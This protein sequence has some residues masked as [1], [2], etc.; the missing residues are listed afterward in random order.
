MVSTIQSLARNIHEAQGHLR[1]IHD[2][3]MA[4]KP[5]HFAQFHE[6]LNAIK[7]HFSSECNEATPYLELIVSFGDNM[8]SSPLP[9]TGQAYEEFQDRVWSIALKAV[10][11][12]R[13]VLVA[14]VASLDALKSRKQSLQK[15]L[16]TERTERTS[17][18][19]V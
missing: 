11:T 13:A 7:V 5:R 19:C 2:A 9:S 10:E 4:V 6:D 8:G 16:P 14:N 3:S 17:M 12:I 18:P 1:R 15:A